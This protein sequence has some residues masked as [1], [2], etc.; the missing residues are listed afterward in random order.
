MANRTEPDPNAKGDDSNPSGF[1]DDEDGISFTS[2]IIPG[3]TASLQVTVTLPPGFNSGILNAWMDFNRDG[4]WADPGE[5]IFQDR[6][7]PAGTTT[8]TFAVPAGAA[9]GVTFARFRLSSSRGLGF[10]GLAADGEVEDYQVNISSAPMD[11]GDAPKPYPTLSADNGAS[12]VYNVDIFLGFRVDPEPDGQPDPNAL[13]DDLNGPDEDGVT[14]TSPLIP[15]APAT[16][17]VRASTSGFLNAWIDFNGNGSWADASDRV[18]SG[19]ALAAGINNLVFNVPATASPGITFARF[20]FNQQTQVLN[21]NGPGP[22]GEVEDYR[23]SIIRDRDR[24]DLDCEGREYW[25][26]FPGNYAPD[27]DNP[28]R[29]T[30]CLHGIAGTAVA[31]TVPGIGFTTNIFIPAV[32]SL[33]VALPRAAEMGD[34]IDVVTNKGIHVVASA[35]I[36]IQAF[37]HAKYT[38]DSYLALNTS[39]L[40]V[41]YIVQGFE[42]VHT[43]VPPLNG[44]QFALVATESNTIVNITPVVATGI[45]P[46]NVPYNILLQ[47]GDAYQLRNTNDAP[48]DLAGTIIKSSKPIAVFGGHRCANMPTENQWFCNYLVEQLL[49]VNTWGNEFYTAPLA[50]RSGGD[51]YRL[52]AAYDNTD[53]FLNGGLIGT[54][55]RGKFLQGTIITGSHITASRPISVMQYANSADF[56]G[57][58]NS[59]P[60]M[61]TVQAVRHYA[62]AYRVCAP[63]NDFPT[64]FVAVIAPS[65]SIGSIQ[66][67]G[68]AI[69]GPFTAI[70]ASG[71]SYARVLITP[72]AHRVIS[73]ANVRFACYVYGWAEYD[74]YRP[75]SLLLFWGCRAAEHNRHPQLRYDLRR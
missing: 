35:P 69:P 9:Q 7:V 72:G 20:R 33:T 15:G 73:I 16:V 11:Y 10:V 14:F 19:T 67:D 70:G 49:P 31:I 60:F 55:N 57:N 68:V 22:A 17:Q 25:L 4:D 63:T 23:V 12:H 6:A 3:Q 39:V 40:G 21:F 38:S 71:F 8:L 43:G 62:T 24:C 58:T 37:D 64:N 5:Q 42:N 34:L 52:M 32:Q 61:V 1:S 41:E 46:A 44:T 65:A 13:G 2:S 48:S 27:P 50:T 26:T 66:V 18:F 29:L 28:A 36:G 75:S 53:I 47:P 54:I 59:D 51:T 74:A 56:D 30:L 45:H